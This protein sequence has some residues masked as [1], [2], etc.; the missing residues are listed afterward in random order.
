M[1]RRGQNG[2]SVLLHLMSTHRILEVSATALSQFLKHNCLSLRALSTKTAKIRALLRLP[3]ISEQLTD[4]CK[5]TL[6]KKLQDMDKKKQAT[7]NEDI[8]EEDEEHEGEIG[9]AVAR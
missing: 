4:A 5:E 1:V 7:S 8:P 3:F 6:D 9:E 2:Q